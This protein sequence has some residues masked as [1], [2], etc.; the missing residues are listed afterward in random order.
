MIKSKEN[1]IMGFF[2]L[3]RKP[4]TD[5]K[6]E[7]LDSINSFMVK[8]AT[9]NEGEI[10]NVAYIFAHAIQM[11]NTPSER[12][13]AKSIDSNGVTPGCAALNILQN[14]AMAE[15]K[16]VSGV[17]FINGCDDGAY[18]FYNAVN[19]EK[20][21]KGYISKGQYEENKLLGTKLHLSPPGG[22]WL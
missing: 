7:M 1:K 20:L 4:K 13:L 17:D 21:V 11:I 9:S 8:Y 10:E 18:E 14:C 15:I 2:N 3:F 16:Q 19:E 22:F 5:I 12:Q 6:K